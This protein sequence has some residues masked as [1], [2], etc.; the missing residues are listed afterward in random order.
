MKATLSDHGR[1]QSRLAYSAAPV[2]SSPVKPSRLG[3]AVL[4][5]LLEQL[6]VGMVVSHGKGR[7]VL[8]YDHAFAP[9]SRTSDP[10]NEWPMARA[11]RLGQTVHDEEIDVVLFDGTRRWLRVNATPIG[12]AP[13]HVEGVVITFVDVTSVKQ[14]A[15]WG[16]VVESVHRPGA[17]SCE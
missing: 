12:T 14:Q 5:A 7:I 13:N 15:A 4:H 6:P 17:T 10:A 3:I 16:P 9:R 1:P 2:K 11:L 8:M